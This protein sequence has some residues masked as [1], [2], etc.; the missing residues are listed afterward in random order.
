[1]CAY[2]GLNHSNHKNVKLKSIEVHLDPEE[3]GCFKHYVSLV[4]TSEDTDGNQH[5][6][7]IPKIILPFHDL[8]VPTIRE[9]DEHIGSPSYYIPVNNLE[10]KGGDITVVTEDGETEE[11]H[12][13]IWVDVIKKRAVKK[14]TLKEIEKKLGYKIE[15]V[16]EKGE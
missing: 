11:V 3:M 14:M 5:E 2:V 8:S 13:K 9:V 10:V 12:E 6:Y 15:L 7:H 1:M 4:Y 16:S